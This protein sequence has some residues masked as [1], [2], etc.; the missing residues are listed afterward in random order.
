MKD[1]RK[2]RK[3][4]PPAY[5]SAASRKWWK[6]VSENWELEPHHYLLLTNTCEALDR[7]SAAREQ[8]ALDGLFTRDRY[9]QSKPHP[10]LRIEAENRTLFARLLREMALDDSAPESRPPM[11]PGYVKGR[12]RNAT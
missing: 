9:G 5:L 4:R 11:L 3:Q 8:V 1:G 12:G 6:A 2:K 7:V 10:A